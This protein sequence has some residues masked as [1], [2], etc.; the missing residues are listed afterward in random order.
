MARFRRL[1]AAG[2]A[3]ALG[4]KILQDIREEFRGREGMSCW[5]FA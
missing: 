4:P 3:P 1:L 5:D 2:I